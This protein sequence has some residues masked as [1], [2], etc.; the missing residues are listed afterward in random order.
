VGEQLDSALAHLPRGFSHGDFFAGNVLVEH[1]RLTGVIDWDGGGPGALPLL[2]LLHLRHSEARSVPDEHWGASVVQ[3]LVPW[4]R[5]AI[6]PSTA[7]YAAVAGFEP[8][9]DTLEALVLAYWLDRLAYQIRTHRFRQ[10]QERWLV[11]N[12]DH[13]LHALS[14][15]T[16]LAHVR[17]HVV[18]SGV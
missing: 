10:S 17:G 11:R 4:A 6:D 1:G 13:V 12:V 14:D 7:R 3:S 8:D 9:P 2:D 15:A 18:G 16:D 5:G